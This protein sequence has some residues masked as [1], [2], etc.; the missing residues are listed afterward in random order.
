MNAQDF[1]DLC[2]GTMGI[3]SSNA[4]TYQETYFP[5]LNTILS[6]VFYLENINREYKGL[7]PLTESQKVTSYSDVLVY[8]DNILRNV[9]LPGLVRLF[10]INDDEFTKAG[11]WGTQYANAFVTE[12]K[13]VASDIVDYYGEDDE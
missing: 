10:F 4:S 3:N 9:V 2:V 5:Q 11:F 7:T 8:Q 12:G 1:F 6:D 13:T